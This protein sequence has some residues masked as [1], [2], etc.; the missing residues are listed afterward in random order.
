MTSTFDASTTA[1]DDITLDVAAGGKTE[2]VE[3]EK[4]LMAA[5]RAVNTESMGFQ[6]AGVQLRLGAVREIVL[7]PVEP[8]ADLVVDVR[9]GDAIGVDGGTE[10]VAGCPDAVG[11]AE[12]A[13]EGVEVELHAREGVDDL[14]GRPAGR[15]DD[16]AKR[17]G[18]RR[19]HAHAATFAFEGT[20]RGSDEATPNASPGTG[21]IS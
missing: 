15:V 10:L 5:G 6:E 3:V 8:A 4:V 1:L 19:P 20:L 9:V 14:R 13:A 11:G 12:L 21:S 2:K 7:D 17:L 16:D 18:A